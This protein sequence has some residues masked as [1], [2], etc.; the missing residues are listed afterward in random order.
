MGLFH[1][2]ADEV[3]AVGDALG[4]GDFLRGPFGGSPVEGFACCDEVVECSDGLRGDALVVGSSTGS[5]TGNEMMDLNL[6]LP[7]ES[8]D[9]DDARRSDPRILDPVSS[10]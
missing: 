4:G 2:R 7:K 5:A 9:Q 6:P 8:D 10:N 1:R 3:K